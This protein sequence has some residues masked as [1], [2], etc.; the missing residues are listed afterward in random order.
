VSVGFTD[1]PRLHVQ[2]WDPEP[3]PAA[4]ALAESP[5]LA[6]YDRLSVQG[7]ATDGR[8]GAEPVFVIHPLE[9]LDVP[10]CGTSVEDFGAAPYW[11]LNLLAER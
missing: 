11:A 8:A 3:P 10:A 7:E 5:D 2:G 9:M 4:G 6:A 1:V